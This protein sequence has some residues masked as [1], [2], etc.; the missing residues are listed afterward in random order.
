MWTKARCLAALEGELPGSFGVEVRFRRPVLLPGKVSFAST[1]QGEQINFA[2]SNV[3]RGT[4]H[5]QGRVWPEP[6]ERPRVTPEPAGQE[7]VSPK[8]NRRNPK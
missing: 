7:R 2:V 5:L 8:T 1:R 6:A 3:E 4:Q